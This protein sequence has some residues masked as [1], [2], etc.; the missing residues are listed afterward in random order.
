M[1]EMMH[2]CELMLAQ[3]E[4]DVR[5][6]DRC[7]EVAFN[8]YPAALTADMKSLRY[9]TAPN[10][11]VSDRAGKQPDICN[12][13]P[14]Y[15]FNPHSHR[16]CQH[17]HAHGWPYFAEYLWLATP[18]DGLCAMFYSASTV[19]AKVAE[20]QDVVISQQTHY[21]FS[22]N[23]RF[24][25]STGGTVVFPFYLRVPGWCAAPVVK[26]NG[27][28]VVAAAA[29]GK[30]IRLERAW[31]NGDVVE[32]ELPMETSVHTWEKNLDCVS[33]DRGP[34]TYSLKIG[35]RVVQSDGRE[36]IR[37]SK[38][39]TDKADF[40]NWPAFELF[41]SSPWNYG[42]LPGAGFTFVD[43]GWPTNDMPWTQAGAPV[44]LLAK[45]QRIPEWHLQENNMAGPIQQSPVLS[46]EPAETV[47][48]LPMGSC[49]LRISAF[50]TIGSGPGAHRWKSA[51]PTTGNADMTK[52]GWQVLVSYHHQG[53]SSAALFDGA[54]PESS[55]DRT[56]PRMT[57]WP[58]K[59]TEETVGIEFGKERIVKGIEVYWFDDTGKGGCRVP[60]SAQLYFFTD[61]QW[62]PARP[63]AAIPLARDRMDRLE[64][65]PV[66]TTAIELR[67]RLQDRFSS[68]IMALGIL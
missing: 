65:E 7:E 64:I 48:L 13:G 24:G 22:G 58:H 18:D 14:M 8:S 19:S 43:R 31:K 39:E 44:M 16:C 34:L 62:M 63:T 32:L 40:K 42:L 36:T 26:I 2:S 11:P 6:A 15:T 30:Y 51:L 46:D 1:V 12:A 10:M 27:T 49:R 53:E 3:V 33:V 25:L 54:L 59:G 41:P 37:Q 35:E 4:G 5:W 45:A 21:P 60:A 17:N 57:F 9:L 61:D 68:G 38:N 67:I 50:P 66:S 55:G 23:I 20:G 47:E 28:P 29:A 56:L 52:E